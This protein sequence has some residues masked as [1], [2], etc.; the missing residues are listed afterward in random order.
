MGVVNK[1]R[2]TRLCALQ[3]E[4]NFRRPF[5]FDNSPSDLYVCAEFDQI[6]VNCKWIL[7][8][9]QKSILDGTCP[10]GFDRSQLMNVH[11]ANPRMQHW[12]GAAIMNRKMNQISPVYKPL[13]SHNSKQ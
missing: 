9:I 2:T 12:V 4:S 3:I 8:Q 6:Q 11:S 10:A 5:Q 13:V 1:S 7:F